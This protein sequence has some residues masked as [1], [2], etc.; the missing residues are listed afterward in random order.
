M[1]EPFDF[2]ARGWKR[3]PEL[4]F[5]SSGNRFL[6]YATNLGR[7]MDLEEGVK[8]LANDWPDRGPA[9]NMEPPNPKKIWKHKRRSP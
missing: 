2:E 9:G 4:D 6:G 5:T 1:S 3:K 7:E 8:H